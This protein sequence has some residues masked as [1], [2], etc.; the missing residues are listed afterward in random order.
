MHYGGERTSAPLR[1]GVS[2]RR[3][4]SHV[5]VPPRRA[6]G[7]WGR[8]RTRSR[9]DGLSAQS[10]AAKIAVE[11]SPALAP[12]RAHGSAP[13]LIRR[14][15]FLSDRQGQVLGR[16]SPRAIHADGGPRQS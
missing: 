10:G 1:G 7:Q 11:C 16:F 5:E 6:A 15:W 12:R 13:S 9:I 8:A 2:A 4:T 3:D 14:R